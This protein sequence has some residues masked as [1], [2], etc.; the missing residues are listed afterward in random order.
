MPDDNLHVTLGFLGWVPAER[1][2][3]IS[4]ALGRAVAGLL[5]GVAT[6]DGLGAFPSLRRARV[7]W[8]GL[9]DP[10]GVVASTAAA[11]AD[12]MAEAGLQP[13]RRPFHAHVTLCRLRT[14]RAVAFP[15]GLGVPAMPVPVDR[16]TLFRSHLGRPAPR[17][18]PLAVF[19][20]RP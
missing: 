8:A 9:R 3:P 12:A 7:V 1:V 10:A 16:V 13:E 15:A 20:L 4:E 11:A 5:A 19:P 17:Y 18:E 14:P 2:Q 6:L